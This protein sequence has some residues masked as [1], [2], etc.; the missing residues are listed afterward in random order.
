M[1]EII[2]G[3]GLVTPLGDSVDKTWRALLAGE[4]IRSHA[5][6]ML[7][8]TCKACFN[9]PCPD[10]AADAASRQDG[11]AIKHT[12]RWAMPCGDLSSAKITHLA[13]LAAREATQNAR[14]KPVDLADPATA[15]VVGTSKGPV[16]AWLSVATAPPQTTSDKADLPAG[17]SWGF[18]LAALTSLLAC[19]IGHGSGPRATLSAACASGIHALIHA[20]FLIRSGMARRAL[21]VGAEASVHPLFIG[22]FQRLGVLASEGMGCRPFDVDRDGFL[23]SEAAAAI[24]IESDDSSGRGAVS[25]ERF[26]LGGDAT[27]LTAGDPRGIILRHLLSRVIDGQPVDLIHAH[28]TGTRFNDPVELAAIESALK[29]THP[30]PNIY[31]HKGA[32]GHSLGASG[33]V[34]IVINCMA[35]RTGIVPPNVQTRQAIQCDRSWITSQ[36]ITRRIRRSV[37]IAAGF[38]GATGAVSLVS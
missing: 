17:E 2:T 19:E 34:S 21:V 23:V 26:A 24:C 18:G 28:A 4:F 3:L 15:L 37:A 5:R 7:P 10:A 33:L 8:Q 31:S 12:L 9:K 22:S 30:P 14:W 35:H 1:S 11:G 27:H 32:L 16:E 38:G 25:I 6:V 29:P 13:L 20:V 36:T